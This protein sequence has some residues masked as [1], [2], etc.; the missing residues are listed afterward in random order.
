[1]PDDISEKFFRWVD[2]FGIKRARAAEM[3]AVDER[4][5]SNYR[6]RGLPTK[7][8][9]LAERLMAESPLPKESQPDDNKVQVVLSDEQFD[10]IERAA[11]IVQTPIKEFVIRSC[12]Q[13]AKEEIS[14]ASQPLPF[15]PLN[16]LRVAEYPANYKVKPSARR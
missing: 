13:R 10:L 1:M 6:S 4:S 8:L 12:V 3:L 11:N 9:P 15:I 16:P 2:A 5:F 14:R 7:K